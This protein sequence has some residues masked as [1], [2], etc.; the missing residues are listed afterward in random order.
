L[1]AF[2]NNG[3]YV[4]PVYNIG[5]ILVSTGVALFVFKEKI[6]KTNWIGVVLA[7]LAIILIS[8]G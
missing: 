4:L 8:L 5:V 7:T 6:A 3:A 2:K 1:D